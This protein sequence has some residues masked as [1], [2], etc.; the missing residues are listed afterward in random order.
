M[1]AARVQKGLC[2]VAVGVLLCGIAFGGETASKIVVTADGKGGYTFDTGVLRGTLC[3]GGKLQGLTS[4]THVPSGTRLD[5]SMGILSHYR[6]FTTG[7]RY[8]QGGWDWPSTATL[9]SDTAVQV[10]AAATADRPFEFAAVYRWKD[11]Q[12]LDL[13]TTVTARKDL[14]RFE[15]FIA[16][17]FDA[18]FPS[19]SVYAGENPESGGRPGFLPAGKSAGDWQMFPR[20]AQVVPIIQDGRWQLEPNPVSWTI[21]PFLKAPIGIRRAAS[22]LVAVVMA[23]PEDCFAV[24]TPC[25]GESHYSLYLSLFGRDIKAG[26]TVKAHT[27]FTIAS[28]ASDEQVIQLH[29]RY[30]REPAATGKSPTAS[31]THS[32]VGENSQ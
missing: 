23:P 32:T 10:T 25:E 31:K 16:S 30:V 11:P 4:V 20:D 27:R 19:P 12:T 21:M 5:R 9:L 17:Y 26:Q 8:G 7:K 6:V 24:A 29:R 13:E 3:P 15:S 28:A 18:A 1:S 14:S 22:G 2:S